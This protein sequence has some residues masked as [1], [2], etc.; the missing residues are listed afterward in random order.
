MLKGDSEKG[1]EINVLENG[2]SEESLK[3]LTVK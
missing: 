1:K 2:I 3:V